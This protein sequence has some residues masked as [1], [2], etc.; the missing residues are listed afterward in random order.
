MPFAGVDTDKL[1]VT[2]L[3][4][5]PKIFPHDEINNARQS[6]EKFSNA[7]RRIYVYCP[8]GYGRTKLNNTLIEKKKLQ[9]K[10]T[11]RNWRTVNVLRS[12]TQRS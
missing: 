7:K 4:A 8:H 9:V 11:T 5:V 6:E 2:F 3:S 1:H 10:A 12:M